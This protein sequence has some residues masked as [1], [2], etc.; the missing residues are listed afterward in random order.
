MQ[1]K[2]AFS[3]QSLTLLNLHL[4]CRV[5]SPRIMFALAPACSVH[6]IRELGA[7][8]SPPDKGEAEGQWKPSYQVNRCKSFLPC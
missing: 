1:D 5:G 2:L 8:C 7:V 4:S 6:M 3:I